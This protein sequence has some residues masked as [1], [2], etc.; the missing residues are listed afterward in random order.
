MENYPVLAQLFKQSKFNLHDKEF[1]LKDLEKQLAIDN[2]D[3]ALEEKMQAVQVCF[4]KNVN[5]IFMQMPDLEELYA[6]KKCVR[7]YMRVKMRAINYY[8]HNLHKD[9]DL[10]VENMKIMRPFLQ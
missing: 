1:Y 4:E 3:I 10:L 8:H 6:F 2:H 5:S 7:K 9:E